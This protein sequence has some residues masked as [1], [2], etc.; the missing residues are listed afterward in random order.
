MAMLTNYHRKDKSDFSVAY[1]GMPWLYEVYTSTRVDV[2]VEKPRVVDMGE[3]ASIQVN[4]IDYIYPPC[5]AL[6]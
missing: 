6:L 1:E 3:F 2:S 5:G 4:V